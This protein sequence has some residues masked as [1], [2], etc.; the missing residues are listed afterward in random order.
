[1]EQMIFQIFPDLKG[2]R[3]LTQ[4]SKTEVAFIIKHTAVLC[5]TALLLPIY[6]TGRSHSMSCNELLGG[7][8]RLHSAVLVFPVSNMHFYS[9]N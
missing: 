4:R 5:Y 6:T 1:M 8:L 7:G 9:L 2:L 3:P